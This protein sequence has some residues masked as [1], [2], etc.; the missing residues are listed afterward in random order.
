MKEEVQQLVF[1]IVVR[2]MAAQS[3]GHTSFLISFAD[4]DKLKEA[5]LLVS[6]ELG[7]LILAD[8]CLPMIYL[9]SCGYA[10]TG[11]E[12]Y[13]FILSPACTELLMQERLFDGINAKV[14]PS[15]IKPYSVPAGVRVIDA[16]TDDE[17]PKFIILNHLQGIIHKAVA[18]E[19]LT[20]LNE[21]NEAALK[22][23]ADTITV[24]LN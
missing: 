4:V 19:A 6:G 3:E 2:A 12:P 7:G 22:I 5:D 8:C 16:R 20:M 18:K 1:S 14:K 17:T 13:T 11:I 15:E 24:N 10:V 23:A 9:T 21:R